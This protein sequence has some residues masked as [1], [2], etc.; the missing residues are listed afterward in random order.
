M[1][2][3]IAIVVIVFTLLKNKKITMPTVVTFG[4]HMKRW[5]ILVLFGLLWSMEE[6][7]EE[8]TEM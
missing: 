5:Y 8:I 6:V 1:V 2:I 7:I 3:V 4:C